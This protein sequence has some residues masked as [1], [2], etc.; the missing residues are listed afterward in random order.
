MAY[1]VSVATACG[2]SARGADG[3]GAGVFSEV[4]SAVDCSVS[5]AVL[6]GGEAPHAVNAI[7][8]DIPMVAAQLRA[9]LCA[10]PP[11]LPSTPRGLQ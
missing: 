5:D 2:D 3:A 9:F 10:M 11:S 8:V 6:A 1:S 7:V 4:F